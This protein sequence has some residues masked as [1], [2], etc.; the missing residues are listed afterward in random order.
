MTPDRREIS[1]YMPIVA[2]GT[3]T[4]NGIRWPFAGTWRVESAYFLP[5]V[6]VTANDTNYKDISVELGGTE[7]ASEQ[8]TTGDTGDLVQGTALELALTV[9]GSSLEFEQGDSVVAKGT[10]GGSGVVLHGSVT[11]LVQQIR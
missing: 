1:L 2:A 7:I 3:D 9:G 11:L 5:D 6:A 4:H 10:A 8:T